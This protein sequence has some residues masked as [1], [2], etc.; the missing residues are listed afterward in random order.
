MGRD[1]VLAALP[2]TDDVS[3]GAQV[4]VLGP[5]TGQL[6]HAKAGSD[7]E[8][9][10]CVVSPTGAGGLV[11]GRQQRGDLGWGQVGQVGAVMALGRDGHHLADRG[12]G[13]LAVGPTA[14]CTVW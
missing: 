2:A 4:Q 8:L 7:R 13:G 6:G 3:A 11:R 14:T 10:Q 9:D 5:Q 12:G 1:S